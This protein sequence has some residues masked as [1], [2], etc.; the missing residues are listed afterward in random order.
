MVHAC[1]PSTLYP[2]GRNRR[3]ATNSRSYIIYMY[4]Y[5]QRGERWGGGGKKPPPPQSNQTNRWPQQQARG[6]QGH[7]LVTYLSAYPLPTSSCSSEIKGSRVASVRCCV[8]S[9]L[10]AEGWQ[11]FTLERTAHTHAQCRFLNALSYGLSGEPRVAGRASRKLSSLK[12][13][14]CWGRSE[15]WWS[16]V[17]SRS[18]YSLTK[19]QGEKQFG[20]LLNVRMCPKCVRLHIL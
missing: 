11:P 15:N 5:N 7:V 13:V 1:N 20:N 4:V 16:W 17:G 19:C 9:A 18:L 12:A 6:Q 3:I 10:S 14:C 2:G 8:P